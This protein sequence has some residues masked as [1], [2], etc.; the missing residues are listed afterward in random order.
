GVAQRIERNDPPGEIFRTVEEVLK[1]L[2]KNCTCSDDDLAN[3][4]MEM[5]CRQGH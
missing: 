5:L 2:L 1:I 4:F 3:A